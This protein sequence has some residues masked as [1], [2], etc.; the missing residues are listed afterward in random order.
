MT[1]A[2]SM[3]TRLRQ[4][5][6]WL[7]AA[8]PRAFIAVFL[9]ALAPRLALVASLDPGDNVFSDVLY[10]QYARNF[11]SGHGFCSESVYGPVGPERLYA[12]RPPLFPFLWGLVYNVTRGSY[13]PIRVGMAM[14]SAVACAV[15]FLVGCRLFQGRGVP[16]LGALLGAFYPPLI[17][18]GVHLM[19]E[20]LFILF[21]VLA[22]YC[23]LRAGQ[24]GS[25]AAAACAGAATG[26]AILSRSAIAGFVPVAAVW[27]FWVR[28]QRQKRLVMPGLFCLLVAFIGLPWVLRNALVLSAF[29][30][31]TTDSGHGFYVANNER[32]LG[33]RRG[34]YIPADWAFLLGKGEQRLDEVTISRR[35]M[36]KGLAFVAA[37]P[38]QYVRLLVRRFFWLW[39]FYPHPGFVGRMQVVVYALSYIPLFPFMVAGLVM[40]YAR[41]RERRAEYWLVYLLVGYTTAVYTLFL[42]TI[43]YRVPLMP[44]LLLF[45]AYAMQGLGRAVQTRRNG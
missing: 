22:V 40:A 45:A 20:P 36:N 27:L 11:A 28:R 19:T 14:L 12:F 13:T 1:V 7:L 38:G 32:S 15:A 16:L 41:E 18:H 4:L 26:L 23:I 29:V 10:L 42:A 39:R 31:T 30:P 17:W 3:T 5:V 9:L 44:F 24:E 8:K 2:P 34:F 43:R 21:T 25:V 37:H 6:E 33:D 35:L